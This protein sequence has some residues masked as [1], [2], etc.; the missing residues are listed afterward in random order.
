MAIRIRCPSCQQ[1]LE[2]RDDQAGKKVLCPN[3][4]KLIQLPAAAKTTI[5]PPKQTAVSLKPAPT[6]AASPQMNTIQKSQTGTGSTPTYASCPFCG[7][8]IRAM[9]KKCKHCG[10]WL[11]KVSGREGARWLERGT[12]DARAV[13]RGIKEKEFHDQVAGCLGVLILIVAVI[14]GLVHPVLGVIVFFVLFIP[15]SMWYWKE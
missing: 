4:G 7:E 12:A 9:A 1:T 14:A 2:A 6:V 5:I 3:C 11:D 8:D 15:L 10:E 13:T